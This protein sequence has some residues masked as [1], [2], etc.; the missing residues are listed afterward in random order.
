[1][2]TQY[3]HLR[4]RN[5]DGSVEPRGGITYAFQEYDEGHILFAVAYCSTKD[6]FNKR[7]GRAKASGRLNS[8]NYCHRFDGDRKT[9]ITAISGGSVDL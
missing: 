4:D 7:Y 5:Q 1:M 8:K 9:F 2:K 3:L 6:N